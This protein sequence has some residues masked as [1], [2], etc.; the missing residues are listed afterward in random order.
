[1]SL[2]FIGLVGASGDIRSASNTHAATQ[3][4]LLTVVI[5][6]SA[7]VIGAVRSSDTVKVS[8]ILAPG[9]LFLVL[10]FTG[11]FTA[12]P[13][14]AMRVLGQG[15]IGAARIVV[16]GKT[17]REINETLGQRVCDE[18]AKEDATAVCPAM[19][20]SRIG[21]QMVLDFAPIA[22]DVSDIN[23]PQLV[24]VTSEKKMSEQ[25]GPSIV[26]RVILDKAKIISWQ[27]LRTLG[28]RDAGKVHRFTELTQLGSWLQVGDAAKS[29]EAQSA[30]P[31]PDGQLERLC[32]HKLRRKATASE[33]KTK[34]PS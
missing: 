29:L 32:G 17:C 23:K 19:I 10:N 15:E 34:A 31:S 20:K 2:I 3:L 30:G 33:D 6:F 4:L 5:A 13:A 21:S 25:A 12:I 24:W 26:R 27:P 9:L 14:M 11:S 22:M 7:A 16:S 18:E 28:E 1:M 8:A